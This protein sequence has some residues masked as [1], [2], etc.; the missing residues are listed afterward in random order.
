MQRSHPYSLLWPQG[1]GAPPATTILEPQCV[2]DLDLEQTLAALTAGRGAGAGTP[3]A[4][5]ARPSGPSMRR[6]RAG[7]THER[8][9]P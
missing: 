3:N 9:R 4:P 8:T 6:T 1:N 7:A 5:N 2:R